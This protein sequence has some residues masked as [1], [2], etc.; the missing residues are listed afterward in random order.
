MRQTYQATGLRLDNMFTSPTGNRYNMVTRAHQYHTGA[1]DSIEQQRWTISQTLNTTSP[2]SRK[3]SQ[4][5]C[6]WWTRSPTS[7]AWYRG[8]HKS[9]NFSGHKFRPSDDKI[10]AMILNISY[11]TTYKFSKKKITEKESSFTS[12]FTRILRGDAIKFWRTIRVNS[13]STLHEVLHMFRKN[14]TENTSRKYQGIN[15]TSW[16]VIPTRNQFLSSWN[17]LRKQR[18]DHLTQKPTFMSILSWSASYGLPSRK[19]SLS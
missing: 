15:G 6:N 3:M 7:R 18:N 14:S 4:F 19:T 8:T 13:D 12:R 16:S 2:K 17:N 11:W 9:I 10:N 1:A 5:W